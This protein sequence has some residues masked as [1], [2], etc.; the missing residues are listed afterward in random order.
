MSSRNLTKPGL[1]ITLM[2]VE[3]KKTFY[4]L[5]KAMSSLG[6]VPKYCFQI[7]LQAALKAI[8]AECA[9]EWLQPNITRPVMF[10]DLTLLLV[11]N[12]IKSTTFMLKIV[13]LQRKQT[14]KLV[15]SETGFRADSIRV[16]R[17]MQKFSQRLRGPA[18]PFYLFRL[19]NSIKKTK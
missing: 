9:G 6:K 4:N 12:L 10:L 8:F 1:A 7:I 2:T 14:V 11:S 3:N 16:A 13:Y 17:T 15:F 19:L 18:A 5:G